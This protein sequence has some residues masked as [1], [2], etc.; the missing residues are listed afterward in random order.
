MV[1]YL[2]TA[3]HQYPWRKALEHPGAPVAT[4]QELLSRVQIIPYERFFQMRVLP[5]G[6]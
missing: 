5:A 6:S 3:G 2:T 1:Y 4:R